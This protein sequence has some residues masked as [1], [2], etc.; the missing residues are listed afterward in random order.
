MRVCFYAAVADPTLFEIVEFYRQDIEILR[1]LGHD[2][3]CA[4][5]PSDLREPWDLAWVWW[6]TSGC[7]AVL[8]ARA[9][10]RQAVLVT[11]ALEQEIAG[12]GLAKRVRLL[13]GVSPWR[14]S[15]LWNGLVPQSPLS[16]RSVHPP[17][18][19]R[20]ARMSSPGGEARV[21]LA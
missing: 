1:S 2:V 18:S 4:R 17:R 20:A 8:A 3:Y 14:Y 12:R 6:Q 7:P 10:R 9:R 13:G 15:R 16:S 5:R 21:Q 19:A 11:V